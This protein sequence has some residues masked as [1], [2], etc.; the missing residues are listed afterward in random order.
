MADRFLAL[1][2]GFC[3][4]RRPFLKVPL[5]IVHRFHHCPPIIRFDR[6]VSFQRVI[7]SRRY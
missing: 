2:A 3:Q 7:Q 6:I 1:V 4:R 5:Q